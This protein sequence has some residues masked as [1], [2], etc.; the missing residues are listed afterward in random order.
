[1]CNQI[2][3]DMFRR[4]AI[5]A[6]AWSNLGLDT[7]V[8]MAAA[9]GEYVSKLK[10]NL[11]CWSCSLCFEMYDIRP[12]DYCTTQLMMITHKKKKQDAWQ[13]VDGDC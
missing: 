7:V 5:A 10:E 3:R 2:V 9:G 1:M 11:T 8:E 12:L 4:A 13:C 6:R